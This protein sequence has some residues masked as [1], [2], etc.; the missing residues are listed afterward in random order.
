MPSTYNEYGEVIRRLFDPADDPGRH[1]I[2]AEHLVVYNPTKHVF[3]LTFQPL[4]LPIERD[5]FT[6]VVYI[7]GACRGNG[8]P[9][10]RS[11]YGI[12]FGPG[13]RHNANGLVAP[14]IPQTSTR[15][16]IEALA[17]ALEIIRHVC[18]ADFKL[19]QIKIATDSS[20]LVDAMAKHVEGWIERDGIG[21]TG[22]VVAHYERLKELHELLDEMEY[23]DDGGIQVQFWHVGRSV[24]REA[25]ALANAALDA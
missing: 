24:N 11:A 7:D 16:E 3:Q 23:G 4:T 14:C 1:R 8:T 20:Y 10:A 2:P 5:E 18:S 21:S 9:T 15:A 6:I 19:Q 13:S 12:Y 17:E 25:D 22:K